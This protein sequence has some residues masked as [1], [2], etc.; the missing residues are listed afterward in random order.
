MN[1]VRNGNEQVGEI[2]K[3]CHPS[4]KMKKQ[5]GVNNPVGAVR[6]GTRP[7]ALP[8]SQPRRNTQQCSPFTPGSLRTQMASEVVATLHQATDSFIPLHRF[9]KKTEIRFPLSAR[10][11]PNKIGKFS[12]QPSPANW[13][14]TLPLQKKDVKMPSQLH[15]HPYAD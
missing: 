15:T 13:P 9:P 7:L 10:E 4:S 3:S 14:W 1:A 5:K 11:K 6:K 8:L 12:M 2:L